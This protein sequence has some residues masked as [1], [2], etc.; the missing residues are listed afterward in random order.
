MKAFGL[1]N[2]PIAARHALRAKFGSNCIR[3]IGIG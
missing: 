3:D 2:R 1:S